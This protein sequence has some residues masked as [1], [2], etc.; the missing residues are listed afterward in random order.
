MKKAMKFSE[1]M[2]FAEK[3]MRMIENM[4]T[5]FMLLEI[6]TI[7]GMSAMLQECCEDDCGEKKGEEL[8]LFLME[9]YKEIVERAREEKC[10]GE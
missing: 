6:H 2:D 3:R 7:S 10:D 5:A 8:K 1:Y 4:G 9:S